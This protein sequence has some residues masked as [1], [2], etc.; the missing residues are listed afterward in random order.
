MP[1]EVQRFTS[2]EPLI[3]LAGGFLGAR[4][5][6]HN[7]ILG[8]SSTIAAHP[9]IYPDHWFLAAS[10]RGRVVGVA[11]QTP[12][13]NVLVSEMDAAVVA[14][15]AAAVAELGATVPGVLGPTAVARAFADQWTAR[16]HTTASLNLRERIFRIDRVVAPRP[17]S[18]TWRIA[19]ERDRALLAEWSWAFRLEAIPGVPLRDDRH[20]M[21]DRWIRRLSRTIYLWEDGDVVSLA[22]AGGE[23]PSGTRIGPVYTPRELRGRGYASNLVAATTQHQLDSGR[24]FCFLFTDLA[25]PTSNKIYQAL[26]FSPVCDFD[27]YAFAPVPR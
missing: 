2:C 7:L 22:G 23:T 21:A 12:P 27:Q 16:T 4:E 25:N 6:E 17:V 8:L 13:Q 14:P 3:A 11:M 18:G 24:Q 15:I 19:E 26:G 20:E 9:E 5:A 1:I 10:D